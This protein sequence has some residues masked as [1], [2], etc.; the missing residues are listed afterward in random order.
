MVA[1]EARDVREKRDID[2]LRFRIV[3]PAPLVS[4]GYLRV[5]LLSQSAGIEALLCRNE[6]STAC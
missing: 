6:C 5:L 4:R 3:S 1:R 2:R